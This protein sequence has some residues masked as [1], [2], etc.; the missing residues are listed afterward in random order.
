MK[1]RRT[2]RPRNVTLTGPQVTQESPGIP[3]M[4]SRALRRVLVQDMGSFLLVVRQIYKK[5]K[6]VL[7]VIKIENHSE[8]F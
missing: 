5:E 2:G 1:R 8:L 6:G 3:S 4:T 7:G